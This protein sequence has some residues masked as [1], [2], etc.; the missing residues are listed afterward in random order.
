[1]HENPGD[2]RTVC[3]RKWSSPAREGKLP[4]D[5]HERNGGVGLCHSTD[6][7][8]EQRR[9]AER[10]L[11]CGGWGGKGA[12]QG[13]HQSDPHE[14]DTGRNERRVTGAGG[15]A[16]SSIKKLGIIVAQVVFHKSEGI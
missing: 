14:H 9:A 6:E 16:P 3:T 1:M 13:K 8:A 7:R 5:W 11:D 15:C 10:K 12:H 2:L 4:Q